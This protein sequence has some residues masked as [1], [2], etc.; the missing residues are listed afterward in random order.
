MQNESNK[1]E[2]Q[3]KLETNKREQPKRLEKN[4][5]KEPKKLEESNLDNNPPSE[6]IHPHSSR[7]KSTPDT[8][9]REKDLEKFKSGE[10]GAKH[11]RYNDDGAPYGVSR[12]IDIDTN[13]DLK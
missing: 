9:S 4:N 10:L 5:D 6:F 7:P 1:H 11:V 3:K 2:P 12:K 8:K 13:S